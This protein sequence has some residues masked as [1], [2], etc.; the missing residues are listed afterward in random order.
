MNG[1][2][3]DQF[4]GFE[5][6]SVYDKNG[7]NYL[8]KSN[9]VAHVFSNH[10]EGLTHANILEDI[11][12]NGVKWKVTEIAYSSFCGGF[13][14]A[15]VRKTLETV[16][17]PKSIKVIGDFA[18]TDCCKLNKVI[19]PACVKKIGCCAFTDCYLL[20]DIVFL[21]TKPPKMGGDTFGRPTD[22]LCRMLWLPNVKDAETAGLFKKETW[23]C[24]DVRFGECPEEVWKPE[25][26]NKR[27]TKKQRTVILLT[28]SLSTLLLK[29]AFIMF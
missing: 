1:S 12:I 20:K 14:K 6:E 28:V 22:D 17:M 27:C 3:M 18:F 19:I 13:Y 2:E 7:V 9:G 15:P 8:L 11:E 4:N 10:R 24:N 26:T 21:G 16:T 29:M 25:N 23:Y 5:I